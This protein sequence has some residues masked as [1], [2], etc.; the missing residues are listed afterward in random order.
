LRH[1]LISWAFRKAARAGNVDRRRNPPNIYI[2]HQSLAL[3]RCRSDIL[4]SACLEPIYIRRISFRLVLVLTVT[5]G[6]CERPGRMSGHNLGT[7]IAVDVCLLFP[8][9]SRVLIMSRMD[10]RPSNG[11][12]DW[13]Y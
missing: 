3:T 8:I 9:K 6:L 7:F 12:D 2:L 1:H 4:S 10:N 5:S 11:L 13:S